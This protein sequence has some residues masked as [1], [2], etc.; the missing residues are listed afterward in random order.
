MSTDFDINF[1]NFSNFLFNNHKILVKI[2]IFCVKSLV[3][4]L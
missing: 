1:A 3:F 4:C 2:A